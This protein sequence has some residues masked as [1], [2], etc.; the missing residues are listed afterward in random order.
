MHS[1]FI[2]AAIGIQRAVRE[3]R[4]LPVG[5]GGAFGEVIMGDLGQE[6]RLDYTLIGAIVNYASR[7]CDRAAAGEIAIT[8]GLFDLLDE[9]SKIAMAASFSSQTIDVKLKPNDPEISG[10]LFA[11][12]GK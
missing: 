11:P 6:T 12:N 2:D 5:V 8:D 1:G 9:Q 7:M 3:N 10:V 4:L